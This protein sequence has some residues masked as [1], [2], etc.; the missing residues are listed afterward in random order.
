[1]SKTVEPVVIVRKEIRIPPGSKYSPGVYTIHGP[2]KC[3]HTLRKRPIHLKKCTAYDDKEV[4]KVQERNGV[5]KYVVPSQEPSVY[6][7]IMSKKEFEYFEKQGYNVPKE[8]LDKAIAAAEKEKERLT[9]E[10]M[11]RKE[12]MR[13]MDMKRGPKGAKLDEIE[14]E[15][16]KRTIHLLER[17]YNL[18]IEQEEEIQKCNRLIL[19]TK[20]RAIR[21][22]QIAEKKLIEKE[23]ADEE[24]R[25]NEMM[26][27]E[28][29]W[30]I[31]LEEEKEKE[32]AAKRSQFAKVLKEQIEENEGQRILDFERKQ[33]ESRLINLKNI[34]W[35]QEEMMKLQ[36]K[37]AE[38]S[39]IRQELA[40]GNEQLK[41]FKD[42]EREESRII[43]LRIQEFQR[44]KQER[45]RKIAEEQRLATLRKEREKETVAAQAQQAQDLQAQIDELNAARVQEQV[46]REWRQK[47]KEEALKRAETQKTLKLAREEQI[48]N[49]RIMQ[50]MEIEQERREFARIL[51][52]QKEAF[53]SEMK[54]REKKEK[55]AAKHRSEIL[56]QVNQKERERILARQKMLEEGA[57]IREEAEIRKKK[58]RE[59]M[60]RKC[61]EMSDNKVPKIYIDE[62]RRMMEE[63]Q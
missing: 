1:M 39:R 63:I 28:R 41:H 10:S 29:R 49:K 8:E 3:N 36:N 15:A 7:K 61:R 32:E 19:E 13:K 11:A 44:E 18:K 43:E 60:E 46:E 20:C 27:N 54:E 40:E 34:A 22:A 42:M 57:M 38:N 35:Q 33:E 5:R 53:C 26:E 37:E 62:V 16:R 9:K 50:A 21:D 17:A 48:H 2:Q 23:L 52:V 25:L 56:R 31:K 14:A 51:K 55:E 30:A 58:L 6:P 4:V 24:K 45:E 59:A 12:A 47:E